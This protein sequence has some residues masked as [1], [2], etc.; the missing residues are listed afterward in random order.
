M[1]IRAHSCAHADAFCDLS[2]HLQWGRMRRIIAD[3]IA[4]EEVT[5]V[6]QSSIVLPSG[7]STLM[8][9]GSI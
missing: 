8:R 2:L 4:G 5:K 1:A 9:R 3:L 7:E 6:R